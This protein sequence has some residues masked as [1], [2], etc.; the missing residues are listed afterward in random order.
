MSMLGSEHLIISPSYENLHQIIPYSGRVC[1]STTICLNQPCQH[2]LRNQ[3]CEC[4]KSRQ[5]DALKVVKNLQKLIGYQGFPQYVSH[6][7]NSNFLTIITEHDHQLVSLRSVID[8]IAPFR[9]QIIQ[10]LTHSVMV[11][12]SKG[13]VHRDL[14]PDNIQFKLGSHGPIIESLTLTG[15]DLS[16]STVDIMMGVKGEIPSVTL[17]SCPKLLSGEK[18]DCSVDFYNLALIFIEIATKFQSQM[19]KEVFFSCLTSYLKQYGK[20]LHL[21]LCQSDMDV[22]EGLVAMGMGL[23]ILPNTNNNNM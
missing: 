16:L 3:E 20:Q 13:I 2:S 22:F 5:E 1:K 9:Y 17:Y 12:H 4:S 10:K 15:F 14:N 11:M 6:E 8:Q 18:Y 21:G 19:Q 23:I 7:F